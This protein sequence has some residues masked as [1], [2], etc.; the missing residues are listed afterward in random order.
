MRT[1]SHFVRDHRVKRIDLLKIDVEKAELDVLRG[2][3]DRDWPKT[4]QIIV[5]VHDLDDRLDT[6]T[7]LLRNK[8]LAKI[9]LE[10]PPTMKGSDIYTVFATR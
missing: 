7:T 10:Q 4:Q 9:K 3:E 8:G 6:V 5:D 1:M 2:V